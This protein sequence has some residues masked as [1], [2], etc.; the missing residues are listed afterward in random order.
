VRIVKIKVS[1]PALFAS[2][3]APRPA[4]TPPVIAD[5]TD[6]AVQSQSPSRRFA[7]LSVG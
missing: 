6:P 4:T 1:A 5:G 7:F 3:P 2:S